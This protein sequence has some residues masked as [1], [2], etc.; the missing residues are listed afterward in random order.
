MR[1]NSDPSGS[2]PGCCSPLRQSLI[3]SILLTV[4][5]SERHRSHSEWCTPCA[6]APVPDPA[7]VS[8]ATPQSPGPAWRRRRC[9]RRAVAPQT[10]GPRLWVF[11]LL[12]PNAAREGLKAR[13]RLFAERRRDARRGPEPRASQTHQ[14]AA[15]CPDPEL[16]AF[17]RF[18]A[19]INCCPFL[20]SVDHQGN[21]SPI[22]G[23][24]NFHLGIL[25]RIALLVFCVLHK[26]SLSSI[27]LGMCIC[28]CGFATCFLL[29]FVSEGSFLT[30]PGPHLSLDGGDGA[31]ASEALF[32]LTAS[33]SPVHRPSQWTMRFS[34]NSPH[35]RCRTSD[36]AASVDLCMKTVPD[37][38]AVKQARETYPRL[39]KGRG[40][41]HE[42]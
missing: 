2:D 20:K 39:G 27:C 25:I 41:C 40:I 8:A 35:T 13:G 23:V 6:A 11:A 37:A 7:V 42:E 16:S 4:S 15:L 19:A 29:M 17:K 14:S 28:V 36:D 10:R 26:R 21:F 1:N 34:I 22:K 33:F 38:S 30:A 18:I 32:T 5:S 12:A 9:C 3:R 31:G 24:N